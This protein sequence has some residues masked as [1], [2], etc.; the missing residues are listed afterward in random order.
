MKEVIERVGKG[1]KVPSEE[2]HPPIAQEPPLY[3]NTTPMM[4]SMGFTGEGGLEKKGQGISVK[5]QFL[6]AR[7]KALEAERGRQQASIASIGKS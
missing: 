2:P 5:N 1:T 3:P 7:V 4:Q 6:D